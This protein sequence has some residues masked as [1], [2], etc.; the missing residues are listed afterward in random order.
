MSWMQTATGGMFWPLEPHPDDVHIED[1]AHALSNMCRFN[2]HCTSFYSVAQ[3]SVLV[4]QACPE[5]YRLAGLLHDAAEAYIGDIIRPIKP[6]LAGYRELETRID[7]AIARRFEMPQP[8]PAIVKEI[9]ERILA[10][11][12]DQVMTTTPE[13]WSLTRPPLGIMINPWPP[14]KAKEL[15]LYQFSILTAEKRYDDG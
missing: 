12:R 3:H 15:F 10:D 11:E 8:M 14:A 9:D 4:S 5:E 13:P 6:H 2:G 1:I 7:Q